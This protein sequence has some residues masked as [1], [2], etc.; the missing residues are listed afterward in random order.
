[1]TGFL[2]AMFHPKHCGTPDDGFKQLVPTGFIMVIIALLLLLTE[3]SF[4]RSCSTQSNKENSLMSM[5]CVCLLWVA[6]Q[7]L[8]AKI[9]C[10][11]CKVL[12]HVDLQ[13]FGLI[14]GVC[15]IR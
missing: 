6:G 10:Y 13:Y 7:L 14:G 3:I 8:L 4:N 15:K 12:Y 11:L 9:H 1:M 5:W 2:G